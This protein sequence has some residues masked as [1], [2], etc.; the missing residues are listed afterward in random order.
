MV[1]EGDKEGGELTHREHQ[2]LGTRFWPSDVR[3]GHLNSSD[4]FWHHFHRLLLRE[5]LHGVPIAPSPRVQTLRMCHGDAHVRSDAKA[6]ERDGHRRQATRIGR[7]RCPRYDA[8]AVT[9][10]S[11]AGTVNVDQW[12]RQRLCTQ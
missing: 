5:V 6:R 1:R 3:R 7:T 12:P 9:P 10:N 4:H 8:I 11:S 2:Q